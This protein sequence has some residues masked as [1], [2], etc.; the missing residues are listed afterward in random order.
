MMSLF[1]QLQQKFGEELNKLI[2]SV[3]ILIILF[4]YMLYVCEMLK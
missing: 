1:E 3:P 4:V 2:A